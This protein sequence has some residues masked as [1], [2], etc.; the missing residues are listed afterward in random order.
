MAKTD[1]QPKYPAAAATS[2]VNKAAS[3]KYGPVGGTTKASMYPYPGDTDYT[4][5]GRAQTK[6]WRDANM[7]TPSGPNHT[8]TSVGPISAKDTPKSIKPY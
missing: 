8:V 5:A 4:A 7:K 6:A 1:Y 2:S 3:N